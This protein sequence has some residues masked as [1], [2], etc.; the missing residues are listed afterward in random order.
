MSAFGGSQ[1]ALIQTDAG[2]NKAQASW[3]ATHQ[4][5][6]KHRQQLSRENTAPNHRTTGGEQKKNSVKKEK[7][8]RP[9]DHQYGQSDTTFKYETEGKA[10]KKNDPGPA[11]TCDAKPFHHCH[12]P[13]KPK[14]TGRQQL[15]KTPKHVQPRTVFTP[16]R[17]VQKKDLSQPQAR[18]TALAPG[19]AK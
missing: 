13:L 12:K 3:R 7:S 19:R 6:T 10:K 11:T 2:S 8:A 9:G 4:K 14:C 17:K 1:R 16:L 15:L 5:K 18:V